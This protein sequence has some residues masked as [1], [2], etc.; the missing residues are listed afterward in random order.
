MTPPNERPKIVITSV[1]SAPADLVAQLPVHAE[2][3]RILP[4]SDRPDYSLAVAKKPIHFRTTVVALEQAGVDPSSADPQMI[5]VHEDGS[6]DLLV[7][8]LVLCARIAGE[9]I[10]LGMQDFPVNIAYI[11][12]NTQLGDAAVDFSKSYFAAIGLISMDASDSPVS[13]A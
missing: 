10:H 2:L 7:F 4:G 8:G 12:D 5:R 9:T 6:V 13:H 1:D 3:V 11:I